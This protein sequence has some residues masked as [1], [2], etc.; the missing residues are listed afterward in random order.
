M[1][2]ICLRVEMEKWRS[3][4]VDY[5]IFGLHHGNADWRPQASGGKVKGS[6]ETVSWFTAQKSYAKLHSVQGRYK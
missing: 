3:L 1:T 2:P 5:N 4:A 6:V